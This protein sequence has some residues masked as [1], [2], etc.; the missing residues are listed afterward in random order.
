MRVSECR[1]ASRHQLDASWDTRT[2]THTHTHARTGLCLHGTEVTSLCQRLTF[3]LALT[4]ECTPATFSFFCHDGVKHA[5]HLYLHTPILTPRLRG[6]ECNC[7]APPR[8]HSFTSGHRPPWPPSTARSHRQELSSVAKNAI[9][10]S[11]VCIFPVGAPLAFSGSA[12]WRRTAAAQSSGAQS[13]YLSSADRAPRG[14]QG[15]SSVSASTT[16]HAHELMAWVLTL[17]VHRFGNLSAK[18][19]PSGPPDSPWTWHLVSQIQSVWPPWQRMVFWHPIGQIRLI[20]A[21]ALLL[22][23][24]HCRSACLLLTKVACCPHATCFLEQ[25]LTL[26]GSASPDH[27]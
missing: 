23:Q 17:E 15:S 11:F 25:F 4:P 26:T 16:G 2:H 13:S 18:S 21:P 8:L 10:A 7:P 3:A 24:T 12:R 19:S 1:R 6:Q 22:Q 9:S 14:C 5:Q 20:A 27:L